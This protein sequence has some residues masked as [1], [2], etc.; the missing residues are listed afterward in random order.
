MVANITKWW[1]G[2]RKH[3]RPNAYVIDV[4]NRE[5]YGGFSAM[6]KTAL[7][8][9]TLLLEFAFYLPKPAIVDEHGRRGD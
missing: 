7:I 5:M 6:Q 3:S 8:G 9:A 4:Y 1:D 2:P